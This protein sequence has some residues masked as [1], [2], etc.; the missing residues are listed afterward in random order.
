MLMWRDRGVS[1]CVRMFDLCSMTL[2]LSALDV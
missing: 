1:W 2:F